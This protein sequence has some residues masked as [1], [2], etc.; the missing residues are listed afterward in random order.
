MQVTHWLDS[1][2][3]PSKVIPCSNLF[4]N[5]VK[6]DLGIPYDMNHM[7]HFVIESFEIDLSE[8]HNLYEGEKF[9][10]T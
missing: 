8:T 9:I 4:L 3:F 5:K 7:I 10:E 6:N 1:E 2:F